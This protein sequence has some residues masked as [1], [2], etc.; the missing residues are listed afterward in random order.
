VP[1]PLEPVF[2][3]FLFFAGLSI[4]SFL[5]VVIARVPEGL[6]VVSP[7][8]R[9]PKCE[10]PI[11]WYDNVP[12]VS[13]LVLRGKCRGC[14]TPISPRYLLVELLT[15][16]LFLAAWARFG[17]DWPLVL[18]LV[19][20]TFLI[21]LTFIDA[22]RWILPFEL[23]LPGIAFGLLVRI[24]LGLSPVL[25]GLKGAV[26]GYLVFRAL[27]F[28][29]WLAFRKEA[30]GA[31][32]K[33]LMALIGAFLS[34][35]ALLAVVFL[36]SLQGALFGLARLWLTGRA[37]PTAPE[38]SADPQAP[39]PPEPAPP[40]MSWA[41]LAPGLSFGRRLLLV[42]YSVLLQNIPDDPVDEGGEEVEWTPEATNLPFG[43]WLAAAALEWLL[44][45]PVMVDL[46]PVG[47]VR[48]VMGF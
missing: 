44:L 23:T 42:P 14:G 10:Q 37:G 6:S 34:W 3:G 46:L 36:S 21:P 11:A 19:L 43:P 18:A 35:R 20:L 2:V 26:L 30:L 15:G 24:P 7:R 47:P 33:F 5:N 32:D 40:K 27:E 25:G 38:A 45:G 29:G 1:A 12:V 4:G 31:G 13:W 48:T 17:W 28:F 16:L 8:S 41:F 22:E 9:C 39:P